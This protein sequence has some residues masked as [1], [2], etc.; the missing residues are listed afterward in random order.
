VPAHASSLT[1][2]ETQGQLV[3]DEYVAQAAEIES[4][5]SGLFQKP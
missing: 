4:T 2:A 5:E 1:D 3:A